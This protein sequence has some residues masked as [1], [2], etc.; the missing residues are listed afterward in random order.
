MIKHRAGQYKCGICSSRHLTKEDLNEHTRKSH[1]AP[2]TEIVCREC[3]KTFLSESS[4]KQHNTA[5]HKRLV[6][7]PVGHP[8]YEI[9]QESTSNVMVCGHCGK[10][11]NKTVKVGSWDPLE[12][13]PTVMMT[14]V[15]ATFVMA[16]F[17]HI[18]NIS[19]VDDPILTEP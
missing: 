2:Y 18:S 7:V 4:L 10:T 14:F 1:K 3:D 12:Q 13:I 16:T 19:A 15:Q 5:K 6:R 17:V 9:Q 11:F 8:E